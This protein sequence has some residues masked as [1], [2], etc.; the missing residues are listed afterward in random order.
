MHYSSIDG[1]IDARCLL[2]KYPASLNDDSL[3]TEDARR[4]LYSRTRSVKSGKLQELI[5]Q[6]S[7]KLILG[8]N[9]IND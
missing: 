2:F 4:M 8:S 9:L 1:C 3:G 6:N 7:E 5:V